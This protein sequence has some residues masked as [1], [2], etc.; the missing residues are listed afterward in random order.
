[1]SAAIDGSNDK[2]RPASLEILY[3][4]LSDFQGRGR[5]LRVFTLDIAAGAQ[6]GARVKE[7]FISSL[8]AEEGVLKRRSIQVDL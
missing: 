7:K 5:T 3:F 6:A 1:M 4:P 8:H 2:S